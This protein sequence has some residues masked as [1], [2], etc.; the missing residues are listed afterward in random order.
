MLKFLRVTLVLIL[1]NGT[2]KGVL[3]EIFLIE[4]GGIHAWRNAFC[5]FEVGYKCVTGRESGK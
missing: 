3:Y 4:S 5:F 2:R 1:K